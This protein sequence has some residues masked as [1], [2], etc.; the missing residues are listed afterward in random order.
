MD[1]K[2]KKV[3]LALT[4]QRIRSKILFLLK[5]QSRRLRRI[6]SKK[7]KEKLFSLIS[8]KKAKRIMFFISLDG[9]VETT[10][11]IKDL[12]DKKL[13]YVPV[14]DKKRK[15]KPCF[16]PRNAKLKKGLYGVTEPVRKQYI[17]LKNLDFVVVPGVAFDKR[18]NRLGRGKGCYDEFL[19]RLKKI[20]PSIPIVG[21]AFDFQILPTIPTGPKDIKVKKVLFA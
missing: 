5:R 16:L 11:M 13:V 12:Q 21:I 4:K 17:S 14:L 20:K 18:G 10:E 7:I 8:F 1:S 2:G 15:I 6:K 3:K 19:R 9:E